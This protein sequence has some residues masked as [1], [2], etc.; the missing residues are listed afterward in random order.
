LGLTG[1]PVLALPP[2]EETPEGVT[3]EIITE[4]R[5][6]VDGS[7]CLPRNVQNAKLSCKLEEHHPAKPKVKETFSV[8][9]RKLIRNVFRF[10][11][12]S[13]VRCS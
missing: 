1:V 8:R 3:D 9:F 7:H 10:A 4:A 2:P 11:D 5:S 6:P 12:L 13:T